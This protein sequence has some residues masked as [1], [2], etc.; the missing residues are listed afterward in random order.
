MS[1]V[2]DPSIIQLSLMHHKALAVEVSSTPPKPQ[3]C[4]YLLFL[5]LYD[6]TL[7]RFSVYKDNDLMDFVNAPVGKGLPVSQSLRPLIAGMCHLTC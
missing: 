2:C 7:R 1:A 6:L 3:T 4:S 5:Q